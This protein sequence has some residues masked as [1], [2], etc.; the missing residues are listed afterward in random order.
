VISNQ[1][2]EEKL[3]RN[4]RA[5]GSRGS[6]R[7]QPLEALNPIMSYVAAVPHVCRTAPLRISVFSE[8][9]PVRVKKTRQNP[10]FDSINGKGFSVCG[11][12]TR[13]AARRSK[14]KLALSA[15]SPPATASAASKSTRS[16]F[17][18]SNTN[19]P[20]RLNRPHNVEDAAWFPEYSGGY[21]IER[22]KEPFSA[23]PYPA[24]HVFDVG[25]NK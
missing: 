19:P 13:S 1:E 17:R 7:L 16:R 10:R 25:R 2:G 22:L 15:M 11:S 9:D 20:G 12:S 18:K 4:L 6:L 21:Q 24:L 23:E 3:P 8:V 5:F 14:A